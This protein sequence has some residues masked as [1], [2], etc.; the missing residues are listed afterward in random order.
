MEEDAG[1]LLHEGFR[2]S[3]RKS[4]VDLNRAGVPLI[5]IV[6][7]PELRSPQ[8]AH[9]YYSTL[10]AILV[11]IGVTDGTWKKGRLRCDANVS[12]RPK[13]QTAFGTR[14]ELKNLNS[15]SSCSMRSSSRSSA[16]RDLNGGGRV[17]QETRLYD[18]KQ[19]RPSRCA[20]RKRRTTTAL[21]RAGPDAAAGRCRLDRVG[22]EE[23]AGAAAAAG[24]DSRATTVSRT[25]R[26]GADVVDPA[27]RL[28]RGGGEG[29]GDGQGSANWIETEVLRKLNELKIPIERAPLPPKR[30]GTLVRLVK[31]GAI[32]GKIAKEVFEAIFESGATPR[33]WSASAG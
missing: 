3:D 23:P 8:E 27:G 17:T 12:L 5:E 14:A 6:S 13:G 28:L 10:R 9:S 7:E 32:S 22:A 15:S 25:E 24:P 21:P 31:D 19:D 33:R 29:A 16:R 26:P 30:L 1:K 11:A 20:R 2:D 18:A 4:Y